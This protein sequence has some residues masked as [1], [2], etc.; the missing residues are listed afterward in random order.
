[1]A[2]FRRVFPRVS[3]KELGTVHLADTPE[4]ARRILWFAKL[5]PV[6]F[7]P[8][9]YAEQREAEHVAQVTLVERILSDGYKPPVAPVVMAM[10]PRPYQA[11]ASELTL[12][13]TALLLCD[14]MGTGKTICA[15]TVLA[16]PRARPAIY[17]TLTALPGQVRDMLAR[18]IPS[19]RVHVVKQGT[20]YDFTK[21]PHSRSGEKLPFPDV[22]V[23]SYSK[24]AG[25]AE[26]LAAMRG[27]DGQCVWKALVAD[28]IHEL[29]HPTSDRYHA[30]KHLASAVRYRLGM[31]G[32]PTFGMGSQVYHVLNI[33]KPGC[34]GTWEEFCREW[35]DGAGGDKPAVKD[36][37]HFGA[38]LRSQGLMLRR[39]RKEVGREIPSL[40]RIRRPVELEDST[41]TAA[42]NSRAVQL[43]IM[44]LQAGGR[45]QDKMMANAELDWRLR[46]DTG[47]RKARPVADFVDMLLES[48]EKV[49]LFAWHRSVYD[50]WRERLARWKPAFYTG[51]ET[52]TEKETAVARFCDSQRA[53]AT[54]LLIMSLRS[55]AGLDGLQYSG[56]SVVVFAELDWAPAVH[57]Q[58]ES[59]VHRDG[60]PNPVMAY[61]MVADSGSDPVIS[62]VLGLKEAQLTGII[63]PHAAKTMPVP[64][65]EAIQRRMKRLAAAYLAKH[66]PRALH[67]IPGA[68]D[69]LLAPA[70]EPAPAPKVTPP[71]APQPAVQLVTGAR[72]RGRSY[73]VDVVRPPP[74]PAPPPREPDPDLLSV[75][76]IESALPEV[77]AP[78]VAAPCPAPPQVVAPR[79]AP[80]V[81]VQG[82]ASVPAPVVALVAA[83]ASRAAAVTPPKPAPR[84]MVPTPRRLGV[85]SPPMVQA[86]LPFT[87]AHGTGADSNSKSATVAQG[88][89]K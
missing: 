33:L 24:L 38:Y 34:L 22:L 17:V 52:V 53:D 88:A 65:Q 46:Q 7:D 8:P 48:G 19:L 64:D 74:Q 58:D 35:C 26:H 80:A 55:G 62:D 44:V 13:S 54:P 1:M 56:C 9:G 70:E 12:A 63:D 4:M 75:D 89:G 85:R 83:S 10:R 61:Y 67:A 73:T 14:Q 5:M 21:K 51:E 30:A 3:S 77:P 42:D 79:E 50:I 18:A 20:P 57:Q 11:Q 25:W 59:R 15:F 37:D 45:G 47:I 78:V 39:T 32:T 68:V 87:R 81:V 29:R 49:V 2:E 16:D 71:L 84:P 6:E 23:I 40:Q 72:V 43:A 41:F 86:T 36:P 31:S 27:D 28:E 60:Q 69:L 76:D 82:P 66:D